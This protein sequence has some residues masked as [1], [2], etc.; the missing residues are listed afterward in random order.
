MKN[1]ISYLFAI[2]FI[3]AY[4]SASLNLLEVFTL[5]EEFSYNP[6]NQFFELKN[7][8]YNL[9]DVISTMCMSYFVVTYLPTF[10]INVSIVFSRNLS[11]DLLY[12]F[13]MPDQ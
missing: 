9:Y 12:F 1:F 13:G 8:D 10:F 5:G 11:I 7:G 4:I 3:S 6:D 2:S